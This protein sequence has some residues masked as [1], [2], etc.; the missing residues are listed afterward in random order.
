MTPETPLQEWQQNI[1][2][3]RVSMS[4]SVMTEQPNN[5]IGTPDPTIDISWTPKRV[6]NIPVWDNVTWNIQNNNPLQ[7][8]NEQQP[9]PLPTSPDDMSNNRFWSDVVKLPNANEF[10]KSRN[11]NIA[12]WISSKTP[13]IRDMSDVQLRDHIEKDLI[14]RWANMQDPE[15]QSHIKDTINNIKDQIRVSNPEYWVDDYY[16]R[17]ISWQ[18]IS[19]VNNWNARQALNRFQSVNKYQNMDA[20][21]LS[22]AISTGNLTPWSQ[23]WNDLTNLWMGK[24]L[25]AAQAQSKF[26]NTMKIKS[27]LI[28]GTSIDDNKSLASQ[29][30]EAPDTSTD[31]LTNIASKVLSDMPQDQHQPFQQALSE[32]QQIV[33]QSQKVND[34]GRQEEQL[35]IQLQRLRDDALAMSIKAGTWWLESGYL[36]AYV[37]EKSK[38]IIWKMEALAAD[39]AAE[40]NLLQTLV[41]NRQFKFDQERKQK[42][43]AEEQR[44]FNMWFG[45]KQ[46]EFDQ[47]MWLKAQQMAMDNR[48]PDGNGN[49]INLATNEVKSPAQMMTMQAQSNPQIEQYCAT[50]WTTAGQCAAYTNDLRE[51]AWE[52]WPFHQADQ[53]LAQKIK[54]TQDPKYHADWP[55]IWGTVVSDYGI[56][57]D[58]KNYWHTETII[59]ING[60][61]ITVSWSN[62]KKDGKVYTRTIDINDPAIKWFTRAPWTQQANKEQSPLI[63]IANTIIASSKFTKDQANAIRRWINEWKNPVSII[64]N[65]AKLTMENE[66]SKNVSA[67]EKAVQDMGNLW[68]LLNEY[69]SKW[70]STSLLKWNMERVQNSLWEVW[71]PK[72]SGIATRISTAIQSYRKAISGTAFSVQ[73]G[74]DIDSVFPWINKSKGLN[75][76][77]LSSRIQWLRDEIDN[78]YRVVLWDDYD[79]LKQYEAQ[80]WVQKTTWEMKWMLDKFMNNK[81]TTTNTTFNPQILKYKA[82]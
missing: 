12:Q 5:N 75:S 25:Q 57:K 82:R 45:Q 53:S 13:N 47:E 20:N 27:Y 59:G 72:L 3:T 78:S 34:I 42:S 4:Q 40:S 62:L 65:Q 23:A 32:D 79:L 68:S 76:A 81:N 36:D 19:D 28:D 80:A 77:I 56:I 6:D 66:Q 26:R 55:V 17:L 15:V 37:S 73:E 2:N 29:S 8:K 71:D 49:Y 58:G 31:H 52:Y 39:K 46:Y 33:Q 44:Q 67:Q 74:K 11:T 38:P 22:N 18:S 64:K 70:W 50:P 35:K 9:I 69:Y 60:N 7:L 21:G 51:R 30:K 48:K 54:V 43:F 63:W 61:K 24:A 14:A 16:K 1:N 10:I 41:Q